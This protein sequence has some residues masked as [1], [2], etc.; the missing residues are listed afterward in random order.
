MARRAWPAPNPGSALSSPPTPLSVR[1]V[2][3]GGRRR[4]ISWGM[5]CRGLWPVRHSMAAAVI[6][7]ETLGCVEG[8]LWRFRIAE[9]E[10]T[11]ASA[12]SV[13]TPRAVNP[14]PALDLP[15]FSRLGITRRWAWRA[16]LT[17][18]LPDPSKH[19]CLSLQLQLPW[20]TAL[21]PPGIGNRGWRRSP[22]VPH[23]KF[24]GG[25]IG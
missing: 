9:L 25:G 20:L 2:R 22:P 1:F 18:S 15:L 19:F 23:R 17:S 16:E 13:W 21:D 4:A 12:Q 14:A 5:F 11:A 24:R 7:E 3:V 6:Q 10:R 8:D